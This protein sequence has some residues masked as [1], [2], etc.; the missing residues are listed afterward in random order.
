M[1]QTSV[2][3]ANTYY[4][5]PHIQFLSQLLLEIAKG[6]LLVPRF[7]RPFVWRPQQQIDLLN[8]IRQGIPIG[9]I[10]VWRTA[11]KNIACY[12]SLGPFAIDKKAQSG[13]TDYLLDGVQRL[14]TLFGALNLPSTR[15]DSF[16]LEVFDD[17][18]YPEPPDRVVFDL[19]RLE[20]VFLRRDE[21]CLRTQLPLNILLDSVALLRYQRTLGAGA[22]VERMV[23]ESDRLAGAFRQ[24]KVPIIP[25]ATDDLSL[26]TLT[27]Q[28]V[29]S[30]GQKMSDYHM[31]HA[32]TWSSSFDLMQVVSELRSKYLNPNGWDGL[33]D[34]AILKVIKLRLGLDV[35]K[36]DI[37]D[38][39][40]EIVTHPH[41]VRGAFESIER[42]AIFLNSNL[43]IPSPELIPYQLQIVLLSHVLYNFEEASLR[44]KELLVNWFW[45]TTYSE[46]FSS[47][48]DDKLRVVIEDLQKSVLDGCPVWRNRYEF[49]GLKPL[50]RYDFRAARTKSFILNMA[51]ERAKYDISF[52][53]KQLLGELGRRSVQQ[54]FSGSVF[55]GEDKAEFRAL[56]NRILCLPREL[57]GIRNEIL[58]Q[59]TRLPE[60]LSP[61]A[62]ESYHDPL[63]FV[64]SRTSYYFQ[65]ES[66]FAD[67]TAGEFAK[68]LQSQLKT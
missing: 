12:D 3:T 35:Y 38:L 56:G 59:S 37:E 20:F 33:E 66:E 27:F 52:D 25:I 2:T 44:S 16:E 54:L 49:N 64:R 5:E 13:T 6:D 60:W 11:N 17:D 62:Q 23:A 46:S 24:Y 30:Q 40:K 39:S 58:A 50:V 4:S 55:S 14:S 22:E 31:L 67:L 32:L 26:A 57:A 42:A 63:S 21:G 65:S 48:S 8:S 61:P 43:D 15:P 19:Q 29:N 34:D 41:V 45:Y 68:Q 9:A 10:M 47:I 7:Q 28:R 51:R 18:V 36:A 53:S 1:N